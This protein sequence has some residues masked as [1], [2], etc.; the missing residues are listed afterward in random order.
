MHDECTV[1]FIKVLTRGKTVIKRVRGEALFMNM[2]SDPL[3]SLF[4]VIKSHIVQVLPDLLGRIFQ[5]EVIQQ[6]RE[7]ISQF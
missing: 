5:K 6:S 7:E 2:I 1:A 4:Y 3:V